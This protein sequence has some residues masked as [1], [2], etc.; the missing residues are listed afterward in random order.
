[1]GGADEWQM[2]LHE[3]DRFARRF[4]WLGSLA[5]DPVSVSELFGH[6]ELPALTQ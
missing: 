5:A 4:V 6:E 3:G 2:P 1:M